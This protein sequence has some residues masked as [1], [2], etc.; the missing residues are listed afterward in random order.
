MF[1]LQE[2]YDSN[3]IKVGN[4]D[5]HLFDYHNGGSKALRCNLGDQSLVKTAHLFIEC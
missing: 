4:A 2:V 5:V 3:R 1:F